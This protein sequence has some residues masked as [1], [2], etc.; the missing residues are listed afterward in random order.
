MKY[1]AYRRKFES[2]KNRP[3]AKPKRVYLHPD[4]GG[5]RIKPKPTLEEYDRWQ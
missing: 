2:Q 5:R 1:G 3:I 4:I